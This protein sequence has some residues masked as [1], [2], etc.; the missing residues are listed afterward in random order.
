MAIKKKHYVNNDDF[1]VALIDYNE[2]CELAK[3][4]NREPPNIP[5]YIGECWLKIAEGLSHSPKFINYTYR[6][7][8]IGD[9]IENCL[10]YFRN[11]DPI[12]Y[13]KPFAYFTTIIYWAFV[14]RIKD[15]R[16]KL[17][18]KY[19]RTQQIG[20]LDEFEMMEFEDGTSVQFELYD[21]INEFIHTYELGIEKKKA[22]KAQAANK[23]KGLETFFE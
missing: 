15:E 10:L 1:L 16:K 22:K 19:K 12:K 2:K 21:N 13:K 6:E 11:F 3:K 14:R 20:M 23:P 7:E 18:V 8:M 4:E 9:G 5:N 17:Y